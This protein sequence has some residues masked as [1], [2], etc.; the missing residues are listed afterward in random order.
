VIFRDDDADAGEGLRHGGLLD[1]TAYDEGLRIAVQ[2]FSDLCLGAALG[3]KRVHGGAHIRLIA[4]SDSTETG[5]T[6]ELRPVGGQEGI[7]LD[8]GEHLAPWSGRRQPS[9][10]SSGDA[11][12]ELE[13][14]EGGNKGGAGGCDPAS[15]KPE[16]RDVLKRFLG[17][18]PTLKRDATGT[19]DHEPVAIRRQFSC[20][21]YEAAVG[22][23]GARK[24]L[25]IPCD[26]H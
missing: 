26:R 7:D 16:H 5:Q 22:A 1:A 3:Q 11:G 8:H 18:Y 14:A 12:R 23:M 17:C 24:V 15:V 21:G 25:K 10:R 9:R 2:A 20:F 19:R 13:E 6:D 4:A